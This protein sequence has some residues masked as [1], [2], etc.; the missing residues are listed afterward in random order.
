VCVVAVFLAQFTDLL[1]AMLIVAAIIAAALGEYA[2]SVVIIIIVMANAILGLTQ[3]SRAGAALEALAALHSPKA[4]V[5]RDGKRI[6]IES[7]VLCLHFC[8][9]YRSLCVI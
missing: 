3:E 7:Y 9:S 4:E 5:I 6:T 2:S 1:V 8:S